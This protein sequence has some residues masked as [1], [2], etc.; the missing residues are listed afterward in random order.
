MKDKIIAAL[1]TLDSSNDNHWTE[2]GLPKLEALRFAFGGP[3]T[4]EMVEQHAPGYTRAN[5]QIK[6]A[7]ADQTS[8]PAAPDAQT[9]APAQ[10][11]APTQ[12]P[13]EADNV[14]TGEEEPDVCC[15]F[16]AS[17]LENPSLVPDVKVSDLSLEDLQELAGLHQ[18]I[19]SMQRRMLDEAAAVFKSRSFFLNDVVEELAKR[20]P[21]PSAAEAHAAFRASVMSQDQSKIAANKPRQILRTLHKPL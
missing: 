3:V 16:G 6:E 10:D 9:M 18:Q 14:A 2:S 21:A 15:A 1:E 12:P 11:S 8:V 4:R 20:K 5:R 13:Q 7:A 19:E 17:M